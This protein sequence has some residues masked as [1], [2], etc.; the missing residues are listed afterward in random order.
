[1]SDGIAACMRLNAKQ[2]KTIDE[3][4][5]ALEAMSNCCTDE[6]RA[7]NPIV[8]DAVSMAYAALAKAR[9]ELQ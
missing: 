7:E 9:G 3:L 8:D 1:M 2:Q 4:C 6:M 5:E